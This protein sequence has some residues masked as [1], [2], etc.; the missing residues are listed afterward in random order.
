MPAR[1]VEKLPRFS[2]RYTYTGPVRVFIT[3]QGKNSL[4]VTGKA[5]CKRKD[6]LFW[7]ACLNSAGGKKGELGRRCRNSTADEK[8]NNRWS[9]PMPAAYLKGLRALLPAG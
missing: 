1:T 5:G 6:K 7:K 2:P 4:S 3:G 9:S 8:K